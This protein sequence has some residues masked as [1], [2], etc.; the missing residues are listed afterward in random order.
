MRGRLAGLCSESRATVEA[1]GRPET[2]ART[3]ADKLDILWRGG[4][5]DAVAWRLQLADA[6]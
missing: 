5:S 2:C 3:A 6:A 1:S 4:A